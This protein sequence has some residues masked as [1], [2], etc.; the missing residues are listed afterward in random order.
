MTVTPM[1]PRAPQTV[2]I[3]LV[4]IPAIFALIFEFGTG[5]VSGKIAL[6]RL[7]QAEASSRIDRNHSAAAGSATKVLTQG[8]GVNASSRRPDTVQYTFET[9]RGQRYCGT[10]LIDSNNTSWKNGAQQRQN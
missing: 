1:P 8:A 5:F 9:A 2:R 6:V 4:I 3:A 10:A 7:N